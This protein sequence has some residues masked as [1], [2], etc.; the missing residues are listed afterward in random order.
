VLVLV[1]VTVGDG[2]TVDDIVFVGVTVY[3]GVLVGVVVGQGIDNR[4]SSHLSLV[5]YTTS[6]LLGNSLTTIISQQDPLSIAVCP[7]EAREGGTSLRIYSPLIQQL[8]NIHATTDLVG[9]KVKVLLGVTSGV[10]V[11]VNVFV[12]VFVGVLVTEA[13]FVGVEVKVYVGVYV[14]VAVCV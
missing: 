2:V 6:K 11:F 13:V 3:V 12:V 5:G 9:V 10:D 1:I 8:S 7:T 14:C 4:H